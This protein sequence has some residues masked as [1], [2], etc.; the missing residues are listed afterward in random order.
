MSD[1]PPFEVWA[2][3]E[4]RRLRTEA[5]N[6]ERSLQAYLGKGVKRAN[7]I[8]KLTFGAPVPKRRK[9][10]RGDKN[11]FVLDRLK[12]SGAHGISTQELF[13]AAQAAGIPIKRPSLRSLL[14]H[15]KAAKRVDN[16]AGRYVL[17]QEGPSA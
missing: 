10:R 7:S 2:P 9:L 13:E 11:A 1:K 8:V 16:R 17:K 3:E 6:L 14:W 15:L 4:I 12:E 5:D